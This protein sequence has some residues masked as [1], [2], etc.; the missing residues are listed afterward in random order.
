MANLAAGALAAGPQT[1]AGLAA[2]P[3]VAAGVGVIG[4]G[5]G[6]GGAARKGDLGGTS[7]PV[8]CVCRQ[9]GWGDMVRTSL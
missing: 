6:A 1:R 9:V 3:G 8:Y 7:E 5:V 4:V 2:Y